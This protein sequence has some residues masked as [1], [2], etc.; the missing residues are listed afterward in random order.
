[1]AAQERWHAKVLRATLKGQSQGLEGNFLARLEG[2]HRTVGGNALR[3]AVLG[4]N[5]GLCTNL[6][7][8]MGVAGASASF[9]GHSLLFT[10]L[11]GLLAGAFS[12]ALG[13]FV[14]VTSSRELAEREIRIESQELEADPKGEGEELKL[15]Y[16]AKGLSSKDAAEMADHLMNDKSQ[17]LDALSR[18]ELGIDPDD[19]GGSPWEAA[20]VSFFLFSAGA[21]IPVFPFFFLSGQTAVE[22]SLLAGALALFIIGAAITI[23]TGRPVW[24]SGG[25]QLILGVAAAGATYGLGRLIGH[26]L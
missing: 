5:D 15:I 20:A 24:I 9:D 10:G 3:A 12:M 19:L 17:A 22:L 1:M 13:E 26:G 6:S 2:R 8:V 18:E 4:A 14:S 7:L 23:F 25:R 16:E 11:A 21:L